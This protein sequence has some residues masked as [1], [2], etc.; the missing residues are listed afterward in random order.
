MVQHFFL[1]GRLC[2][3]SYLFY[4]MAVLVLSAL[5]FTVVFARRSVCVFV[6]ARVRMC[7]CRCDGSSWADSSMS[8]HIGAGFDQECAA[9]MMARV[10][11]CK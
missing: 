4:C 3:A 9:V 10:A 8:Q 2:L 11:V 7:E 6:C 1:H 5:L